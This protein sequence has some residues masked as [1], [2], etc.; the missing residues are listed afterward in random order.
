LKNGDIFEGDWIDNKA[1]G[2]GIL[3]YKNG[4]IYEGE[5]KDG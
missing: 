3:N 5:V 4:N 2:K 1:N